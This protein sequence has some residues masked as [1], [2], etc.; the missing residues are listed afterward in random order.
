MV[1]TPHCVLNVGGPQNN[2]PIHFSSQF[3]LHNW[4]TSDILGNKHFFRIF[5]FHGQICR[6]IEKS[7]IQKMLIIKFW[8][9]FTCRN[10]LYLLIYRCYWFPKFGLFLIFLLIFE[11]SVCQNIGDKGQLFCG[12]WFTALLRLFLPLNVFLVS[13]ILTEL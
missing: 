7:C 5:Q 12:R 1:N 9:I 6:N 8:T 2:F 13:L 3:F 4:F 10:F 11:I